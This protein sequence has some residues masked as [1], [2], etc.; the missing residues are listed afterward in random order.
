MSTASRVDPPGGVAE[1]QWEIM[2]GTGGSFL[3]IAA[4]LL[5]PREQFPV[6]FAQWCSTLIHLDPGTGLARVEWVGD[7]GQIIEVFEI[8][9]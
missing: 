6:I 5:E 7:D 8:E 3:N 2:V 1:N 4:E 9:L